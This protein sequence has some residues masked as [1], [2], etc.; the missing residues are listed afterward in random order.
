MRHVPDFLVALVTAGA[1]WLLWRRAAQWGNG[2]GRFLVQ[3]GLVI[4]VFSAFL[5]AMTGFT[6]FGYFLPPQIF[7]ISRATAVLSFAVVTYLAVVFALFGQ[8]KRFIPERRFLLKTG[9]SAAI[10]AP[11]AVTAAAYLSRD[12]L[13]FR[14]VDVPV[15][16]LPP[17]LEGL[18]IVQISDLHLSPI[19]SEKLIARAI[20]LANGTNAHIA[21]MT[22]DLISVQNDPLDR[23][24]RQ[25]ARLRSDAGIFGCMGNHEVYANASAYADREGRKMG[26][27]FLRGE[28]LSLQFGAARINLAG[29]DYQS[30]NRKYLIG[31]D[32]LIDPNAFNILLSHN[33]D[34][35]PVAAKQGYDLTLS[36]HTHG[37]QV[38]F[39]ILHQD[40]NIARFFT[41]YVYGLYRN[42]GKSIYVTRGVGTIGVP[43]R[44]GAPP[45]VALIRLCGISS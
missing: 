45:E 37:G 5:G 26:I 39:E 8:A 29:V 30:R 18:R 32:G 24:L 38:N 41:P 4:A 11:V 33:P 13:Q 17:D 16:N 7:A 22:G 1:A 40:L 35:F 10:A 42:G 3:T 34:V 15:A 28:A 43:A 25:V 27:R 2:W 23:C 31:A 44:L 6:R 20:D 21:M 9:L 12:N 14:E 36:G 19:V